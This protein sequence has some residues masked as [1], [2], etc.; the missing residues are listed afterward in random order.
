M[1]ATYTKQQTPESTFVLKG[2]K[3]CS[4]VIIVKG[5]PLK[6]VFSEKI[7]IIIEPHLAVTAPPI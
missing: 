4:H 1:D 3:T 2:T 5:T 6:P 7:I